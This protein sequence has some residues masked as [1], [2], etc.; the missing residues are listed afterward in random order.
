[1]T[2]R[3][4]INMVMHIYDQAIFSLYVCIKLLLSIHL[5]KKNT[6]EF[7]VLRYIYVCVEIK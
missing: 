7:Q 5:A 6:N 3:T 4:L 2:V 1:M